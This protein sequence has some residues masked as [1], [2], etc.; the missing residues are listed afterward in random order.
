MKLIEDC[1]HAI[2]TSL[3]NQH[4]GT[5]GDVG[6]FSFYPTKNITTLE[7]GMVITKSKK[8]TNRG[9]LQ[10]PCSGNFIFTFNSCNSLNV[11]SLIFPV[12]F[13]NLSIVSSWKSTTFSSLVKQ[14][15]ISIH[16]KYFF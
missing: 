14:V 12:P 13:V 3:G 11:L 2:G 5:F 4:V 10:S 1:A 16:L 6:C 7:G 8:S 15:S 9:I